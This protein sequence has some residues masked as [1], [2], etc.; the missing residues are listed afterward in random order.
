M[1]FETEDIKKESHA[2]VS[3]VGTVFVESKRLGWE[4]LLGLLFTALGRSSAN[5]P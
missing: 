5:Q 4:L 1:M 3:R 2:R